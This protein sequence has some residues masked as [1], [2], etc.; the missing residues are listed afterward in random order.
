VV[1]VVALGGAGC[2][3]AAGVLLGRAHQH[4]CARERGRRARKRDR[5]DPRVVARR[6]RPSRRWA[7]S[8]RQGGT[9]AEG[10]AAQGG[11][12]VRARMG[13]G[14]RSGYE[15]QRRLAG[16][17]TCVARRSARREVSADG[18]SAA[19]GCAIAVA[20]RV[21]EPRVAEPRV[22]GSTGC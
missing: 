1:A 14:S 5:L 15:A 8:A 17:C 6:F 21:V 12:S 13:G 9:D 2:S 10:R 3:A 22:P 19:A 20:R 18:A 16:L 11:A 4:R 7:G